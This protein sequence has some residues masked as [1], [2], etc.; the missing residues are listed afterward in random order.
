MKYI[1]MI[2]GEKGGVGKTTFSCGF[3]QYLH[4]H[5]TDFVA[6][7]ADRSQSELVQIFDGK[8]KYPLEY[9]YF[10]E[11]TFETY[12]ADRLVDIAVDEEHHVIVDLPAQTARAQEI[13]LR[14]KVE[15]IHAEGATFVKW[16]VTSGE[17]NSVGQFCDSVESY[18]AQM[19]HILV[20]NRFFTDRLQYDFSD[21][22][23]NKKLAKLL[24]TYQV[25][26]VS[27]P[28]LLPRDL[29]ILRLKRFTLGEARAAKELGV[30]GRQR[31]KNVLDALYSELE[32]V[33]VTR[34][35]VGQRRSNSTGRQATA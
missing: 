34:D 29:D 30:M 35:M 1:G 24:K 13:W 18:G 12:R 6:V 16:F 32:K 26:T 2:D 25:Q 22:E 31:I 28:A 33:E 8:L 4:D 17:E 14:D 7:A 27:F 19:P 5:D 9:A 3:I 21:P 23:A 20:R 10:T 15:G 11:E